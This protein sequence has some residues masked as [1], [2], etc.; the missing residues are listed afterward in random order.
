MLALA[1]RDHVSMLIQE[2]YYPTSTS[3]LVAEHAGAHLVVIPGGPDLR[4]NQSYT[5]FL[6]AI[7]HA[8]SQAA[9]G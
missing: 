1:R 8:L 4:A 7:G 9:G 6:D 5:D 3:Q 2:T